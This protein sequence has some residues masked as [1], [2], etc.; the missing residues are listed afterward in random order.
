M[1]ATLGSN[2]M[3]ATRYY[4]S[5]DGVASFGGDPDD[6]FPEDSC[7]SFR[8]FEVIA[9]ASSDFPSCCS[10]NIIDMQ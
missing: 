6:F 5:V 10:A 7:D 8:Q 9:R 2:H 3:V 4:N 1:I